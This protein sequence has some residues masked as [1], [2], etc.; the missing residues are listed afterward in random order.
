MA[1]PDKLKK[2]LF[3]SINRRYITRILLLSLNCYLIFTYILIPMRIQGESM[4]PTYR[5]ESFAFCWRP[6]YLFSDIKRF[7]IVTIRFTGKSIMLLK[8][9]I[10][11]PG[12]TLEFRQG[13][14]YIDGKQTQEPYV[15]YHTPWNLPPRKIRADHVYVVGD[16]RGTLM[17]RHTFGQVQIKRVLGGVIP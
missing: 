11:L 4:E 7:D 13:I 17:S 14:L 5:N 1:L 8:R 9:V 16:N 12:E 2:F 3:P 15:K 6:Q 10:A